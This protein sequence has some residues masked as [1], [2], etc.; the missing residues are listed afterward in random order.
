ME[1]HSNSPSV[2]ASLALQQQKVSEQCSSSEGES[3]EG[4]QEDGWPT[5]LGA[6]GGEPSVSF[7]ISQPLAAAGTLSLLK[8]G[9]RA[10]KHQD[11]NVEVLFGAEPM[12]A[13]R[14]EAIT[15]H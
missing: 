12:D 13:I 9:R 3:L 2:F 8:F 15:E 6:S 11:G 1:G 10:G 5:A 14:S 7:L 4:Q